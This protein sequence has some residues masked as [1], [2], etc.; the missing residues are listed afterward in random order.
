[1][2]VVLK[3]VFVKRLGDASPYVY[4][5]TVEGFAP[6][7]VKEILLGHVLG[8]LLG[9]EAGDA[10]KI[11][12]YGPIGEFEAQVWIN[13]VQASALQVLMIEYGVASE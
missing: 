8:L 9:I 6:I 4:N 12:I 2:D 7:V 1:M 13:S 11:V 5:V 3:T 10:L